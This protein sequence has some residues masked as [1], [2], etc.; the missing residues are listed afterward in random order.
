MSETDGKSGQA[1]T[2]FSPGCEYLP[3]PGI[4]YCCVP[5]AQHSYATGEAARR[6]P[7][8]NHGRLCA[9]KRAGE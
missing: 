9:R 7:Q 1:R 4:D 5:C 8:D 6:T 2:C 3:S